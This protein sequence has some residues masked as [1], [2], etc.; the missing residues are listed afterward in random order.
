MR[1]CS[2]D[3]FAALLG[4]FVLAGTGCK[5]L[6]SSANR[7]L[8]TGHVAPDCRATFEIKQ[9]RGEKDVLMVLC[10]SGGGSRASWFSAATMLR[11]ERVVDQINLL[12]EVD[13]ISS[14][15]GGSLAAAYY[16]ASRD[17]GPYSVVR[18]EQLPKKLPA[19]LTTAVKMDRQRGLLGVSGKMSLEQRDRLLPLFASAHDQE[20]VE[21][22]YWLSNHTHAPEVWRSDRVRDLMTR[23]YI[24]PLLRAS[25]SPLNLR[26]DWLYW[27]TDYNRSDQMAKIFT[28]NMFGAR[29]VQTPKLVRPLTDLQFLGYLDRPAQAPRSDT[30]FSEADDQILR[31]PE[32]SSVQSPVRLNWI[33]GYSPAE[34]AAEFVASDVVLGSVRKATTPLLPLVP[35]RFKDLNPERPCLILNAT[36]GTEDD[37][38]GLH[39]GDVFTFTREDFKRY[40]NS[41]IDNYDLAHAVMASAAFPGVFSFVNLKDFRSNGTNT[42]PYYLHLFDGG[43]A[44]NLGLESAKK[45]ILANR[46]RYRHF[47]VLVVDSHI[48][49]RGASRTKAD[50]R[51]RVLDMNFMST[52]GTLL[53]RVRQQ[54]LTEFESGILDGQDLAGKLTFW[55][56]A[57]DDVRDA[58]LR[59][60]ANRIPTTFKIKPADVEVIQQCVNGLVRPDNPKLQE[61]L[62]V[63]HVSPQTGLP[64]KAANPSL[65]PAAKTESPVPSIP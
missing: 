5:S 42:G 16:C 13:V 48:A 33:P 12:H 56:I 20:C 23:N 34:H 49:A 58:E 52:F 47:I 63:L 3:L 62:R 26:D 36:S 43:N 46:D 38:R 4:V 45:I 50:V 1:I 37:P 44:D 8:Q 55:D 27:T 9:P 57:F 30:G 54:E 41:S 14:V 6:Y 7:P 39:F 17:P 53:E 24:K 18:A 61:I 40:L 25:F 19:E 21:R 10:L 2:H 65:L 64:E 51:N 28:Q 35:Y 60:K 11:L 22:L 31:W 32:A 29:F 59:D 15:S